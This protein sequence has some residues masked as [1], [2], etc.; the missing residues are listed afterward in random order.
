MTRDEIAAILARAVK[1][2]GRRPILLNLYCCQGGS[3]A[4][5]DAAGYY[6]LG[7]DKSPQP[8]Y[9]YL[10]VLADALWFLDEFAAWIA[11]HVTLV[12]GSPPCQ[13]HSK[14]QKIMKRKHPRLIAPTRELLLAIGRP[15]VL[16][17][18][19]G[20]RG[21]LLDPVMLC[22]AMFGMNTYR[23]RLFEPH[24]WTIT[25]PEHPRHVAKLAK[26]GRP[27]KP[28]EFVDYVGN[29]SGVPASRVDMRMSWATRDGIREAV[30]PQYTEYLGRQALTQLV[31]AGVAA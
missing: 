2:A 10:F 11:E 30:P 20:A 14:A 24:G 3:A 31:G 9:P 26:M 1:E 4:G 8:K 17:N 15:F 6:V 18:V 29:Y 27:P 19:E 23:H 13:A 5:Y 21:E 22:G 16:E 28:G 12:D 7:V 25:P